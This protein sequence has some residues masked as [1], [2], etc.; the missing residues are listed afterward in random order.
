MVRCASASTGRWVRTGGERSGVFQLSGMTL[1]YRRV[2][3]ARC[4]S[5]VLALTR[6]GK[7]LQRQAE[8]GLIDVGEEMSLRAAI[9]HPTPRRFFFLFFFFISSALFYSSSRYK[10]SMQR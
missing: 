6:V 9:R 7:D 5:G 2:H 10:D 4:E 3:R 1:G 8:A